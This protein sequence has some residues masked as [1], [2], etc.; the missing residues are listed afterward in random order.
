MSRKREKRASKFSKKLSKTKKSKPTP[1]LRWAQKALI[2]SAFLFVGA[3]G[4]VLYGQAEAIKYDLSVIGKGKPS[5]VQ[6]HDVNCQLCRR[7][8]SNL[9]AVKGPFKD[10]IHFKIANISGT[11]GRAFAN[12]HEVPHVTLLFFDRTGERVNTL[13]G[14]TPKETIR[15]A[16]EALSKTRSR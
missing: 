5:V 15:E 14:V 8:K 9:D 10:N 3:G 2:V 11:K 4:L 7:L 1:W 12:K 13:Q 16:L 6:V